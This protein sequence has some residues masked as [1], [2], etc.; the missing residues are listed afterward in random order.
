MRIIPAGRYAGSR[1]PLLRRWSRAL[2]S[3]CVLGLPLGAGLA[4]GYIAGQQQPAVSDDVI[5]RMK[6][7]IQSQRM[8]L[9]EVRGQSEQYFAAMAARM[10]TLQARLVR[11]DALGERMT[12]LAKLDRGEFDF[13]QPPAMGGPETLADREPM[14]ANLVGL[15]PVG[16]GLAG[17]ALSKSGPTAYNLADLGLIERGSTP[18]SSAMRVPTELGST[19]QGDLFQ[20]IDE[21]AERIDNREQQLSILE[22]LL[23]NRKLADETFLTGRPIR[24]GWMSSRYGL[25][26]DPFTGRVAQH[27]GVD[28]AGPEGSEI[29][30]VAAGV[31]TWSGERYGYGTMV[32]VSHGGGY[33][34]RYAHNRENRVKVGDI[35][36]KGQ[37]IALM[38]SSGRSTGP[39]VHFEVY[40]HGRPVDPATYIH[41][42]AR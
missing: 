30:S 40:K 13:S 9:D 1:S 8:E 31:V 36:K 19:G 34:T 22:S 38:G 35:I 28:F 41:R 12:G 18:Y 33:M 14:G 17:P 4:F 24:T 16:H 6:Q 42:A 7:K 21:L 5:S 27:N 23:A 15:S 10:A 20:A 2:V 32:E 29:I 39:H 3:L 25:R 37:V 26:N 11:L